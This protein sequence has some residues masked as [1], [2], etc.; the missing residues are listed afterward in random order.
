MK[1]KIGI[2]IPIS[3]CISLTNIQDKRHQIMSEKETNHSP[4]PLF[5]IQKDQKMDENEEN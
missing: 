2:L 5:K 3:Y 1:K 4:S